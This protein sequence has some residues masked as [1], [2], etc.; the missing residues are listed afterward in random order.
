LGIDG[1]VFIGHGRSDARGLVNGIGGAR[2]AVEMDLLGKLRNAIQERLAQV[3]DK[4][5][6]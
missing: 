2:R 3:S 6:A 4:E 1:L 5:T